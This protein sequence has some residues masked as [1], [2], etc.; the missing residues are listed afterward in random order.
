M[1]FNVHRAP[2]L[3][4]IAYLSAIGL[5]LVSELLAFLQGFMQDSSGTMFLTMDVVQRYS[6]IVSFLGIICGLNLFLFE[7]VFGKFFSL[8][9]PKAYPDC[10]LRF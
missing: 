10:Q 4:S 1:V 2:K 9:D 8:G 6:F 7:I 3:P 5:L